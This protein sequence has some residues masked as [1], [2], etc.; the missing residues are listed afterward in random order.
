MT[1]TEVSIPV[2]TEYDPL[3]F[4]EVTKVVKAKVSIS[5][6]WDNENH[7]KWV[8][9]LAKDLTKKGVYV[10]LDQWELRLGHDMNHFMEKAISES[11][12]VICVFTS[13]YRKKAEK[14]EGGVGYEYSII[15]AEMS[16]DLNGNKVIPILRE[17]SKEDSCPIMYKN[18][19]YLDFRQEDSYENSLDLLLREIFKVESF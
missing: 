9:R 11:E 18:R 16:K 10:I 5:Y 17:G 7:K 15:T 12:R 3:A 13:N 6:S 2:D 1:K 19:L 14:L 8:K 4:D